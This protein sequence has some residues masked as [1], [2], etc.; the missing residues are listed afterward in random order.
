MAMIL[1]VEDEVF[2]R[3]YAEWTIRDLGHDILCAGD[4]DEA[5]GHLSASGHIDTLFV[6]IR[7]RTR[8]DGGYEVADHAVRYRPM[9]KVLYTSGSPLTAEMSSRF[10]VGGLFLRKP[11]TAPQLE[12]AFGAALN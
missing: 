11:Y 10:V 3:Q 4:V 9:L 2:I 12:D 8:K 1:I 7:L 5:L 6:D